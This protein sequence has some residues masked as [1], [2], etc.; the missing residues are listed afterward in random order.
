MKSGVEARINAFCDHL[1][2][3]NGW[4]TG[5]VPDRKKPADGIYQGMMEQELFDLVVS[6]DHQGEA[7]LRSFVNQAPLKS[8]SRL[9]AS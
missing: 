1:Y 2:N 6:F 8:E 9:E 5:G 3:Q 4:M 7:G